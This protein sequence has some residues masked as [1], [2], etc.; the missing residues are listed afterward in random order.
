MA[1]R[2]GKAM[3]RC[4]PNII[5]QWVIAKPLAADE[6]L[7][8][9]HFELRELSVPELGEGEAL[10]RVRLMNLHAN[11]RRRIVSEATRLGET[12]LSNYACVEIVASRD[13]AF[14]IGAT[15]ACQAGWQDYQV[16]SSASQSVGYG[17]ASPL[18]AMVNHTKS[19]W[20]YVFRDV[21]ADMW[22]PSILLNVLGTSGM[23]AYFGL[24]ECGP[25]L[26]G[27]TVVI[28]N[29]GGAV[30]IIAAQLARRAGCHVIGIA[31]GGV[32][33]GQVVAATGID[34]CIDY[35][36]SDF[37]AHLAQACPNGIDIFTDGVAGELTAQVL[38][39]MNSNGRLLAYGSTTDAYSQ[40]VDPRLERSGL[41]PRAVFVSAEAETLIADKRIKVESWIV[42]DFYHE[43]LRAEEDL[44]R[45]MMSGE[46]K[47][48][49]HESTGFDQ[50]P[51]AVVALY[52]QSRLGKSQIKFE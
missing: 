39:L 46:L 51:A 34:D 38:G 49:V 23:T 43:R 47:S 24:R 11:T 4:L 2:Q 31:G 42:H 5:R 50:L 1:N 29:A 19:Q 45:Q 22:T 6:P 18:V 30:G 40:A 35:Q 14:P 9:A 7:T 17:P 10:A 13:P 32:R 15:V 37:G 12:D 21:I 48:I 16:I 41:S 26:P 28:A 8:A 20:N 27:H 25:L 33:C 52:G 3:I 44:S 36:R